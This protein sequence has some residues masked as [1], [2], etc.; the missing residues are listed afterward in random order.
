MELWKRRALNAVVAVL[1]L[2]LVSTGVY[3]YVMIA[4][5]GRDP[6]LHNSLRH[7]V[8]TYTGT[9]YGADSPWEHPVSNLL[10]TTMDLS[11]FLL[12]FIVLPYVFKPALDEV[13]SPDVPRSTDVTD[14]VLICGFTERTSEL[15][16]ELGRRGLDYVVLVESEDRAVEL[17]ESGHD[18][19]CG[20]PS[21]SGD[22]AAANVSEARAVVVDVDDSDS[23]SVVLSVADASDAR[24]TAL[25][26][27]P[28]LE[29]YLRYAG[30]H[31]V[32]TPRQLLGR[33]IAERVR[34]EL[35]A[36]ASDAVSLDG[37]V[38][39]VE[40]TVF[41]GSPLAGRSLAEASL[42]G[43]S[44]HVAGV[45]SE[46]EF[47]SLP[48][49]DHV[50]EAHSTVLLVGPESE[51]GSLEDRFHPDVN[52]GLVVVAGFGEVGST[53]ADELSLGGMETVVVD[54]EE[55]EGVDVVGDATEEDVLR[56][57]G[58]PE[59]T[60]FVVAIQSDDEAILSV[61]VGRQIGGDLDVVAR[62]NSSDNAGKIRK[63]G[64][65]Y[66]L[67]L[68]EIS[69]RL[70]AAEVLREQVLS[71]DRQLKIVRVDVSS[72]ASARLAETE[73]AD[74]DVVVVA[75]E[76]DDDVVVGVDGDF[77]FEDGDVAL[78]AGSDDDVDGVA[79]ESRL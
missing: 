34:S 41:D 19:V 74:V 58:V 43:P 78:V 52:G 59:A 39:V 75:V 3:H 55:M 1:V 73:L 10:I 67:S 5:E 77:V 38:A 13:M 23:A 42:G 16:D 72:C 68:P 70:L 11:T 33:R 63:A 66:V 18:V 24:I 14:H 12:L 76:R 15:V 40:V 6:A 57:A 25:V 79:L 8:E 51:L 65:D 49:D 35:E 26:R 7:V 36:V 45:W 17:S 21:S 56:E 60:A 44:V 37:D 32:L 47:D 46:G 48:G 29:R 9:G 50:L 71:F 28:A 53:V 31:A 20:D 30:A 69:G 62:V 54:E 4:F 61:L 27:D 22:L 2:I 64:A